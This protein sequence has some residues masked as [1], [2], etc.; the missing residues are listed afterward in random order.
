[1]LKAVSNGGNGPWWQSAHEQHSPSGF[2]TAGARPDCFAI[3]RGGGDDPYVQVS[4]GT[5]WKADGH[6]SASKADG[7][8]IF[9]AGSDDEA[10]GL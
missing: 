2:R 5:A 3:G 7:S 4:S 1:M 9:I 6:T 10:L 8:Y